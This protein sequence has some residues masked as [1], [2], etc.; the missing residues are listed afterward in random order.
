MCAAGATFLAHYSPNLVVA[1]YPTPLFEVAA[2]DAVPCLLL[3]HGRM[4]AGDPR[5]YRCLPATTIGA[6]TPADRA[7]I[8]QA[9]IPPERIE[10]VRIQ[11]MRTPIDVAQAEPRR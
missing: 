10:V 11:R 2:R 3:N 1:H 5:W 9:G 8:I 7:R 6:A 4:T